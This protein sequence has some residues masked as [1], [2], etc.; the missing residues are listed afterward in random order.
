MTTWPYNPKLRG[1]VVKFLRMARLTKRPYAVA[2]ALSL[3]AHGYPRH[4]DDLDVFLLPEDREVWMR[5][6]RTV[7]LSV[8]E[9]Y[10]GLLTIVFDVK[11]G[12]P[13]IRIDMHFRDEKIDRVGILKSRPALVG[14][15][16]IKVLSPENLAI[17]KLII[18]TR[19]KDYVDAGSM[20]KLGLFRPDVAEAMLK[21]VDP[22]AARKFAHQIDLLR[23]SGQP[24]PLRR[25]KRKR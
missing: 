24:S 13:R 23:R 2:G 19:P 17:T 7:G 10:D 16:Q 21:K 3:G 15:I 1:L 11:V 12:D 4:T 6:A 18:S 5:A 14:G 9:V 22:R 25:M 20:L 8:S